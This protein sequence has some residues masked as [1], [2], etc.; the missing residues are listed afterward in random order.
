MPGATCSV[1]AGGTANLY[2]VSCSSSASGGE[3]LQAVGTVPPGSDGGGA[4]VSFQASSGATSSAFDVHA[5]WGPVY[6]DATGIL[7]NLHV[8]FRAAAA[9][10]VPAV[11]GIPGRSTTPDYGDAW[12]LGCAQQ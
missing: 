10:G 3:C 11:S 6:N 8:T 5:A 4:L 7:R 2:F 1:A 9:S 12:L